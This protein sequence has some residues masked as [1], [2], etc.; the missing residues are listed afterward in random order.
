[1]TIDLALR[2]L[3]RISNVTGKDTALVQGGGGNT[4]AK[5]ADGRFMYIKASGTALKDMSP[6]RGWR[7]MELKGVLAML[8][9]AELGRMETFARENEIVRR[10]MLACKDEMPAGIRPSVEAHFHAMLGRYVIHLHPLAVGAYVNAKGGRKQ[11]E[12]LFQ[13]EK[14]P[15][16]WVPYTDP[17]YQL[18]QK[19]KRLIGAYQEEH[20]RKP[21]LVFLEKHGLIVSAETAEASLRLVRKVIADLAASDYPADF[22]IMNPQ[23]WAN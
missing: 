3:I 1:M 13:G 18:A 7:R 17:G 8:G 16:L 21:A 2:E 12:K 6:Q 15:P 19:M 14:Y 22:I 5:T 11:I 20:G 9:D 23:D 4:S 10:L